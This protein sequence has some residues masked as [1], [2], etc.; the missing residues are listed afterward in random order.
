[1]AAATQF[2]FVI[3]GGGLCGCVLAS[4]LTQAG[5]TVALVEAGESNFSDQLM[6]PLAAPTLHETPYEWNFRSA[7]QKHLGNR[8]LPNYTGKIL[9][10]S[11][12]INYGLWT[13]CH[14][15][16]YDAWAERVGDARWNY[17][18]L[19]PYFK[20]C[21]TH[22]DPQANPEV[23]GFDGPIHTTAGA[24][25]YPLR[26]TIYNALVNSGIKYNHDSNG[27]NPLGF[28]QFTENW[29]DA[30]RQPAAKMYDLSNVTVL[31]STV[32][33]RIIIGE[34]GVTARGIELLDK[35]AIFAK[36]EVI[37]SCGA[38]KTPQLLMLSGIG[39]RE[40]LADH[41][42]RCLVDLPVGKNLHDHCSGVLYWKLR[43]P[44]K[45]L[46]MGWPSFMQ[47]ARFLQGLPME[48]IAAAT[49]PDTTRAAKVDGIPPDD[50]LI[51]KPR[52]HIEIFVSYAPIGGGSVFHLDFDGRHLST[53]VIGL[54][55]TSRGSVRLASVD[56][57]ADPI[58]D[59]NYFDTEI[60]KEA[61]RAGFRMAM[62]IMMDTPEGK[63]I[64]SGE[65]PPEGEKP[66][67]MQSTDEEID[68]RIEKVGNSFY[69]N[70]GTAEMGQVV[71]TDMRVKGCKNLRV[72]DASVLPLPLSGHYQCEYHLFSSTFFDH[73]G[74]DEIVA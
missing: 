33:S 39:P 4:R 54:L 9:S 53:P 64:V 28:G 49:I 67:T 63:E 25:D 71:G 50:P 3:A 52:A 73:D 56:P 44:D 1:M 20:K 6:S 7:P 43:D 27:G 65:T 68:R 15:A 59:P 23:Y 16:D 38:I 13:R 70:A 32:V 12:G 31:T 26:K 21:Q 30:K 74:F 47:T 37:I 34:D 72:V 41:G 24:R 42:I 61:A 17:E 18:N 46:A 51:S 45:G 35:G 2:D 57:E 66:L 55:P 22:H 19:L 29:R 48:W 60:D 62:R 8:Q 40:Q 58:I 10:G 69:Q 36:R 5:Y 14:S 11:S